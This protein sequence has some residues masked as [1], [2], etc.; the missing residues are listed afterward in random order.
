M[1]QTDYWGIGKEIRRDIVHAMKHGERGHLAP[2]FSVV[3]IL[4]VLFEKIMRYDPKNPE[5][6]S[7]DRFIL[8]KGHG[9]LALYAWLARKGF[10][11]RKELELFCRAGG[12]LGGHPDHRKIPGV[13]TSTGSLGHGLAVGVGMALGARIRKLDYRIFVVLG[14]GECNEGSIWE[15][16]LHAAKHG[17]DRLVALVDYNKMQSYASTKEVLDLEPM[18]DKWRAF[19]FETR[20]VDLNHPERLEE[21][22]RG[23]P[24]QAGRPNAVICH[25]TKGK[26]VSFTE[27]NAS[28]HHKSKLSEEELK[29]LLDELR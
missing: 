19:G 18:T 20:E 11:P 8:S 2:A 16:A 5:L 14:D 4:S 23:L 9:C 7:R 29:K 26:G 12:I 10:F 1:S 24:F 25:T 3:E 6:E 28:W 21:L 13:E 22:L 15:S 17:L 27:N